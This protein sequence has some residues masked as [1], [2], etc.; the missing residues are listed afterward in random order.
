M[1]TVICI[2]LARPEQPS[3][4]HVLFATRTPL[5][6]RSGRRARGSG[7]ELAAQASVCPVGTGGKR[8]GL[9]IHAGTNVPAHF[10]DTLS[11]NW[12]CALCAGHG[13]GHCSSGQLDQPKAALAVAAGV[14]RQNLLLVV[15]VA[16]AAI[17]L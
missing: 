6:T 4:F 13:I 14:Y 5:G 17:G 16:L 11:R 3:R 2:C 12:C 10:C 7:V 9:G 15:S 8:D 1:R